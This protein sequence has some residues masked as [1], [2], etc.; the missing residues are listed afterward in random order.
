MF[1]RLLLLVLTNILVIVTISIVIGVL[2]QIFHIPL[3]GSTYGSLFLLCLIWGMAGAFISLTM[4][5]FMARWMM[6]VHIVDPLHPGE[7]GD[8][9][10]TVHELAQKARL[11]AMPE[12]GVYDSPEVNAFATGPSKR[13]SLVAV[14]TGLYS[15]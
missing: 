15:A 10:I 12:V 6:G 8:L 14:S 13:R 1:K 11:P 3:Y 5:K 2:S 4:S 9:V 7:F